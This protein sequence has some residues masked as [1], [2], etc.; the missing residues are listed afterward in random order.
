MRLYLAR[1]GEALAADDTQ[2]PL[3][4]R[5]REDVEALGVA[6]AAAGTRVAEILHSSKLRAEQTAE[7]LSHA[8]GAPRFEAEALR[9]DDDPTIVAEALADEHRDLMLVGHLPHLAL[10]AT[11]LLRGAAHASIEFRTAGL[12]RLDR[13]AGRWQ[14]T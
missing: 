5:G 8:L 3:S 7:I 13:H 14:L 10:L 9:P 6:L 11:Y 2:P 1:H 12:V 4:P